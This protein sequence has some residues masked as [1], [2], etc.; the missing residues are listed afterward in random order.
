[1]MQLAAGSFASCS[2]SAEML[3]E[4]QPA[5]MTATMT[6]AHTR[7]IHRAMFGLIIAPS[8]AGRARDPSCSAR[9]RYGRGRHARTR[10]VSV[11]RAPHRRGAPPVYQDGGARSG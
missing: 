11:A 6:A 1:M 8:V 10:P 5:S 9:R 4:E 3:V 7:L 2:T